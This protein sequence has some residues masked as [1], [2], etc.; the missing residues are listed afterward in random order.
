MI[1]RKYKITRKY[2]I[3]IHDFEKLCYLLKN[4]LIENFDFDTIKQL[5]ENNKNTLYKKISLF[6]NIKLIRFLNDANINLFKYHKIV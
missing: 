3:V 1:K 4:L 5:D 6:H 2:I